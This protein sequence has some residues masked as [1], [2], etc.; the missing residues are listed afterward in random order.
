MPTWS[1]LGG[2][3]NY[4]SWTFTVFNGGLYLGTRNNATGGQIWR[5]ADGTT[6]VQDAFGDNDPN[7]LDIKP[8]P[9]ISNGYLYAGTQNPTTGG[10]VWRT[11]NGT[12]WEQANIDGFGD[13]NNKKAHQSVVFQGRVFIGTDNFIEG[14]GIWALSHDNIPS[15]SNVSTDLAGGV[16][17]EFA[18]V[19]VGGSASVHTT[20]APGDSPS[21]F[22]LLGTYYDISTD[23]SYSGDI[24]LTIP[25]DEAQVTGNEEDLQL[26]HWNGNSWETVPST[27]D[28]V[29]NTVTGLSSSLSPFALGGPAVPDPGP[30]TGLNSAWL[31]LIAL[32]LT[33]SGAYLIRT[34]ISP[35]SRR[36]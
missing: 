31:A 14:G 22:S 15:G 3:N 5:T 4:S 7:N 18:N 26:F 16:S 12:T 29:N 25:Y 32:T 8:G 35:N 20:E 23:A 13:A 9:A 36:R 27:A 1:D 33:L 24:T 10:E 19:S 34:K 6:W 2:A 21:G 17:I 30:P 28:T 11:S